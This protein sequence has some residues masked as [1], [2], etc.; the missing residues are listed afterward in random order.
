MRDAIFSFFRPIFLPLARIYRKQNTNLF[1][2]HIRSI[3]NRSFRHS[4][5]KFLSFLSYLIRKKIRFRG[6]KRVEET[7][8]YALHACARKE[9]RKEGGRAVRLAENR[10]TV[11]GGGGETLC[12]CILNVAYSRAYVHSRTLL[13]AW[14][15]PQ[16][17]SELR[18]A[19]PKTAAMAK[20]S[21]QPV[22]ACVRASPSKSMPDALLSK[23]VSIHFSPPS[24]SIIPAKRSR[25][26]SSTSHS[27]PLSGAV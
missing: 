8:V 14:R 2:F 22:C 11:R 5:P 23:A 1:K 24:N 13:P 25:P 15:V 6:E 9:I 19:D 3:Q 17:V 12:N 16:P 4:S 7:G 20:I 27:P 10:T 18:S 26:D 21:G